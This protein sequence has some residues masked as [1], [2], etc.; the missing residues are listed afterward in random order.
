[1]VIHGARTQRDGSSLLSSTSKSQNQSHTRTPYAVDGGG[2]VFIEKKAAALSSEEKEAWREEE[3]EVFLRENC[4]FGPL[5]NL[6]AFF[7]PGQVCCPF[8][9]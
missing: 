7:G 1:M 5:S 4:L 9:T 3:M 8:L 2:L 6:D